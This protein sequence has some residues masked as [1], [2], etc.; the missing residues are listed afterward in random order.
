MSGNGS[1]KFIHLE[2]ARGIA[3]VIV[4]FHHFA[5]AF[6]PGLKTPFPQGG[7]VYTPAYAL[8]NGSGAVIFFFVLSGFV[9]SHGYFQR[10]CLQTLTGSVIKRLPR[11]MLPAGLTILAGC[12][13]LTLL[14][15]SFEVAGH[16]TGSA[17]LSHFGH[18]AMPDGVEPGFADA[19]RQTL[20]V[21]LHEEDDYYN[22]NLRT[23]NFEFYGSM[24]VFFGLLLF[25]VKRFGPYLIMAFLLVFTLWFAV[26]DVR[27]TPF[28]AGMILS[29][30][31][32]VRGIRISLGTRSS[33]G[34]LLL[35]M[36]GFMSDEF[37]L[38]CLASVAVML[39]LLGNEGLAR[40]FSGRWSNFIGALSFPLYLVHTLVIL[41]VTSRFY[42]LMVENGF[43]REVVLA[44]AFAMTLAVAFLASLPL[45]VLE[46]NW[47]PF[48]NRLTKRLTARLFQKP[49]Q[50]VPTTVSQSR[51]EEMVG[52]VGLEPTTR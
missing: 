44:S 41:S 32:V 14:P 1:S 5:L 51:E 33:A 26:F 34:L 11:L 31:V 18:S 40:R 30:L 10:P 6:I 2:W 49:A 7:L 15:H 22:T 17:W 12:A 8:M 28:L 27:Y 37:T 23:M 21:F 4:L 29:Y 38:C 3:S 20:M 42:V 47:V 45:V 19:L 46:K 43:S 25:S 36:I 35:A 9:L 16:M 52:D 13:I 39:V 50:Q 24:I 48:L